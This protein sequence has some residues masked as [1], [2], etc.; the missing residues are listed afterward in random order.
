MKNNRNSFYGLPR[1]VIFCKKTLISNQKPTSSI[2]FNHN[3]KSKKKTL[4]IDKNQ[5]SDSW[6]Y[7]RIKKKINFKKRE[8]EL[9]KLLDRHRSNNKNYDWGVPGS[10]GK[11]S[12]YATHVLKY[13]YG[14][15]PLTIT[16]SLYCTKYG[17][18]NFHN[19]LSSCK[20]DN[21]SARRDESTMK[22]LTKLSIE[23]LMHPFQTFILG[24]K[25]LLP[26]WH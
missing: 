21:I 4:F 3:L 11:D 13:K 1:K 20:V 23:N 14:M 5:I 22:I 9:L 25:F 10:G 12:C 15:N 2:E 17:K 19:W 7:S 6:K 18:E 16:C 8:K 24:Q 26:K